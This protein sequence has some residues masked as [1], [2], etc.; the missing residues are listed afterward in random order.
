MSDVLVERVKTA[1][2]LVVGDLIAEELARDALRAVDPGLLDGTSV[3][4]PVE[5]TEAMIAAAVELAVTKKTGRGKAPMKAV[6]RYK[7]MLEAAKQEDG[8]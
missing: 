4:V 7:A 5:P 8:G 6:A 2:I 1:F 3:V